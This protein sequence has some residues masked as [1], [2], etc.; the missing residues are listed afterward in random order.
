MERFFS[1]EAI[2][3]LSLLKP[4]VFWHLG[5]G[6]EERMSSSESMRVLFSGDLIGES[7]DGARLSLIIARISL[8]IWSLALTMFVRPVS[9]FVVD[10][11]ISC[12]L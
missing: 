3:F 5:A 2:L 7:G 4:Y 10:S 11:F 12:M 6:C 8:I 9:E 1:R